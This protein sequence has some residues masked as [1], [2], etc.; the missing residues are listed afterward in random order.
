MIHNDES[1]SMNQQEQIELT[2]TLF[3]NAYRSFSNIYII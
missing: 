1:F 3:H 2:Q